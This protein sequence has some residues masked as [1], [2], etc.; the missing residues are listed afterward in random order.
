MEWLS[1]QA[2]NADDSQQIVAMHSMCIHMWYIYIDTYEDEVF[3]VAK[4]MQ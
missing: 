4:S 3:S 2:R 1:W